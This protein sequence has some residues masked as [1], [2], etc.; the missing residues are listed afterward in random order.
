MGN[1]DIHLLKQYLKESLVRNMPEENTEILDEKENLWTSFI[2]IHVGNDPAYQ[3][4]SGTQELKKVLDEKLEEYNDIKATMDLVL[5]EEAMQHVCKICRILEFPVGNALL[6]GVG[7]SGKQ[8]LSRL[9]AFIL[10]YDVEQL[11]VTQSFG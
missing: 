2:S 3:L 6:V 4:I 8:S 10:S 11:V 9:S 5:F 7:G 1:E